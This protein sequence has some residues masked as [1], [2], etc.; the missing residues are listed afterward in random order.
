MFCFFDLFRH[1]TEVMKMNFA[2]HS[3]RLVIRSDAYIMII[4]ERVSHFHAIANQ[5]PKRNITH[6]TSIQNQ[7]QNQ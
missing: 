7:N 2:V 4:E 5:K 6:N 1:V 3:N